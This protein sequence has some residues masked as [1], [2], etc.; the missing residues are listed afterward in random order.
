MVDDIKSIEFSQEIDLAWFYHSVS[1]THDDYKNILEEG[2]KCNH[3]LNKTSTGRFNGPYYISL[4]NI[5]IP[6]NMTFLKYAYYSKPSIIISG[7]EPIFCEGRHDYEKYIDTKDRRRISNLPGE[8]QYYYHIKQEYIIGILYNLYYYI[9]SGNSDSQRFRLKELTDLI[10]LLKS[11]NKD[12]PIY[13]YSRRAKTS[14]HVI[15]KEKILSL[16]SNL[17]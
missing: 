10:E 2:I 15:D 11:L 9:N 3:L 13:D 1:Y 17:Y 6:D 14:A 12:I 16:T 5:T 8:Y 4:S 7:I